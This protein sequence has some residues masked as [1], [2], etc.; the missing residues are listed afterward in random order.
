M[1]QVGLYKILPKDKPAYIESVSVNSFSVHPHRK[2]LEWSNRF[3]EQLCGAPGIRLIHKLSH[4][5]IKYLFFFKFNCPCDL[6][7]MNTFAHSLTNFGM[8]NQL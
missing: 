8:R 1:A 3:L 2:P 6:K 7:I 4:E 5:D